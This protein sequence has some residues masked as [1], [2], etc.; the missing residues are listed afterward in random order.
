MWTDTADVVPMWRGGKETRWINVGGTII[1]L[2]GDDLSIIRMDAEVVVDGKWLLEANLSPLRFHQSLWDDESSCEK[3]NG[4]DGCA[5]IDAASNGTLDI[6]KK[7]LSRFVYGFE[8]DL[9]AGFGS[10]NLR[11][12]LHYQRNRRCGT[13]LRDLPIV[14]REPIQVS[15]PVRGGDSTRWGSAFDHS[16]FDAHSWPGQRTSLDIAVVGSAPEDVYP[17]ADGVVVQVKDPAADEDNH[18]ITVWHLDLQLWTGYYHLKPG[19]LVPTAQGQ[20]VSV[21]TPIAQIGNSERARSTC[22]PEGTCSMRPDCA[23]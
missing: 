13:V 3:L 18:W 11:V 6:G 20:S 22:T 15:P 10:G 9:E 12:I 8:L 7:V 19:T 14:W 2:T 1:N 4:N 17:M 5:I 16:G 23:A 21:D